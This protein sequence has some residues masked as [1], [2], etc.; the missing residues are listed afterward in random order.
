MNVFN[1]NTD[2]EPLR[3][4]SNLF[5]FGTKHWFNAVEKDT[6]LQEAFDT[7]SKDSK[8]MQ[9]LLITYLNEHEFEDK[10][11]PKKK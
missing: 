10:R 4:I 6:D 1:T 8:S 9:D 2:Q 7:L 5:E 11:K 3:V